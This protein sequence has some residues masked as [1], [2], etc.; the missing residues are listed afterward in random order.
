MAVGYSYEEAMALAGDKYN[1]I[2]AI[3][4]ENLDQSKYKTDAFNDALAEANRN[5]DVKFPN[6]FF[7][8]V[9]DGADK[10][11]NS[12]KNS[13]LAMDGFNI[14]TGKAL[15]GAKDAFNKF[16]NDWNN[17]FGTLKNAI[18]LRVNDATQSGKAFWTQFKAGVR[19]QAQVDALNITNTAMTPTGQKLTTTNRVVAFADGGVL[20]TPTVGLMAE[21]AGAHTNPEIITP[22]SKMRE[23]FGEGNNALIEVWLQTTRQIIGAIENKD[24]SVSIGDDEIANSVVRSNNASMRRNGTSLFAY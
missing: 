16:V 2:T 5:M 10:S 18:D 6:T 22:E 15:S 19:Y 9:K 8:A 3:T 14:G 12:V 13:S 7:T 20:T 23:V 1:N 17:K 24:M 4:N 21:Y 11:T